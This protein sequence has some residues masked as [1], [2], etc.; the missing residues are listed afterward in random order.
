ME[1]LYITQKSM[2][3]GFCQ[4][5]T[6]WILVSVPIPNESYGVWSQDDFKFYPRGAHVNRSLTPFFVVD[7]YVWQCKWQTGVYIYMIW[8]N[9]IHYSLHLITHPCVKLSNHSKKNS[10]VLPCLGGCCKFCQK[11]PTWGCFVSEATRQGKAATSIPRW[12][13]GDRSLI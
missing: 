8:C 13:H 5:E 4:Q 11:R 6:W 10:V 1:Y 9:I 2:I 7:E 3:R 12:G